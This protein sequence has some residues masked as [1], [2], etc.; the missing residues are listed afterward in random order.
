M[1]SQD[2]RVQSIAEK[3]HALY[4][5][6]WNALYDEFCKLNE[7][8]DNQKEVERRLLEITEVFF[9][10]ITSFLLGIKEGIK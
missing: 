9:D 1:M 10:V 2:L 8:K 5:H 3:W 7:Y 4:K 6:E